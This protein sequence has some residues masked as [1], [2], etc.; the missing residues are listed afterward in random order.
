MKT[1]PY[2]G[3][4]RGT[5]RIAGAYME[6]ATA[7]QAS[8]QGQASVNML[9]TL[10]IG[11]RRKYSISCNIA[12]MGY[13]TS[14][15]Q[16]LKLLEDQI[17]KEIA[18][19]NAKIADL[20]AEKRSLER[21]LIRARREDVATRQSIRKNSARK[22]LIEKVILDYLKGTMSRNVPASELKLKAS[23]IDPTLKDSTFRS[24]LFRLK[25]VGLIETAGHGKWR[26]A[27]K[28]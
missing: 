9:R 14:M 22:I 21:M 18:S 26:I 10:Y 23:G 7:A 3:W 13:S 6:G 19:L 20:T 16:N 27:K 4:C 28:K 24:Y 8:A 15:D 11:P 1:G 2:T 12:R 17:Q 25:E 5:C